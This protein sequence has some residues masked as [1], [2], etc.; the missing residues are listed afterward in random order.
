LAE[1]VTGQILFN[2]NTEMEIIFNIFGTRGS[3]NNVE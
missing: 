1:L 2:G 3:F